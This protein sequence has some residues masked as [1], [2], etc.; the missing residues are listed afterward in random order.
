MNIFVLINCYRYLAAG[1][2]QRSI[3]FNYR[4]SPSS[5]GIIL[6]ETMQAIWD[7]MGK[8]VLPVPNRDTFNKQV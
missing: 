8:T 4:V 6:R 5:V 1:S 2:S 3:G 7:V